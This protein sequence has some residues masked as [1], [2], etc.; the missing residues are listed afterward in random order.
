ME[1]GVKALSENKVRVLKIIILFL[2]I[3]TTIRILR[4]FLRVALDMGL[5][6]INKTMVYV[7]LFMIFRPLTRLLEYKP[8]F[9]VALSIVAGYAGWAFLFDPTGE[10]KYHLVDI[11]TL[12]LSIIVFRYTYDAYLKA[13]DE[14]RIP[15]ADLRPKMILS[16]DSVRK[17]KERTE[18]Y[19]RWLKPLEPDGLRPNQ[20]EAIQSWYGENDLDG[21]VGI[22]RTLPFAPALFFGTLITIV[23]RGLLLVF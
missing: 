8:T 17:F 20:V 18:F 5:G 11:G 2:A 13:T 14:R 4:H 7:I 10:A 21:T 6:D 22:A 16:D 19:Q 12:S 23:V 15:V 1:K 9:W 3:F